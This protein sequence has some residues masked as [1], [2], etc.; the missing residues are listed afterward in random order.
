MAADFL[1]QLV[2]SPV[3]SKNVAISAENRQK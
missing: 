3:F 2:K 1:Q